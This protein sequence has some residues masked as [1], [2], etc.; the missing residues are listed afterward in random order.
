MLT[1]KDIKKLIKA[2]KE[3]FPTAEMV[4]RSFDSVDKNFEENRQEHKKMNKRLSHIE[5]LLSIKYQR[6][7]EILEKKVKRVDP[8]R[9]FCINQ[10]L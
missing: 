7:I 4:K 1:D 6:R 8:I 10:C 2:Q 9:S 3:V 5:L